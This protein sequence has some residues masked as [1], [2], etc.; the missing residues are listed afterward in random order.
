M[1][2]TLSNPSCESLN[3]LGSGYTESSL[4]LSAR[5]KLKVIGATTLAEYRE[6][7]EKGMSRL[8]PTETVN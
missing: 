1:R 2:V 5:G 8:A 3:V 4:R 6:Y 7:I